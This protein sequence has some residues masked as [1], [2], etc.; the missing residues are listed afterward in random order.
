[1]ANSIRVGRFQEWY[2]WSL[3]DGF[4]IMKSTHAKFYYIDFIIHMLPILHVDFI[5]R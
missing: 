3:I 2:I 5:I 1:M 4:G